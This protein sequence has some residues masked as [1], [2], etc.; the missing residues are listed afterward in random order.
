[1]QN[2]IN[3]ETYEKFEEYANAFYELRK[4]KGMTPEK[5]HAIMKD[6]VYFATMMIKMGE[7]DGMVSGA[8]H[9]TADTVRPSLQILKTKPGTSKVSAFS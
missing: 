7:A 1:M 9:S 5:A 2:L 8:A 4:A 3:P 6:Y